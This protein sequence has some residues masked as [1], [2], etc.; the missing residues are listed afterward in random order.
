MQKKYFVIII[1]I[2]S[3]LGLVTS[4]YL[5]YN[6]Y[7]PS[8]GGSF[9]DKIPSAS[10]TVVNSGIYS[11]ILRVPVA[12]YG[13]VW[14]LISGILSLNSLYQANTISKL[15]CWNAAGLLF[16]FYF[17]YLEFLL[18]TICPFCT[19]VHVLVAISLI[20]SIILYKQFYKSEQPT[21]GK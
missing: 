5:T 8:L 20:I 9:C 13:I 17:I 15:L 18:S 10:C 3:V 16:V 19:V 2:V 14:F 4:I 11:K 1:L 7:N 12:I 21:T 6:H